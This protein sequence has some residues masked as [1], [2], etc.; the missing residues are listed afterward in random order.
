MNSLADKWNEEYESGKY[1]D[2]PAIPFVGTI[3]ETLN[4]FPETKKGLGLYVGCGNGRNYL[5]LV[6]AG[7]NL[8]GLDVS[9][10]ALQQI[11]KKMPHL[12]DKLV[13]QDFKSFSAA[14]QFDYIVAI[15]VFQ[16]GTERDAR[17]YFEKVCSLLKPG[18]LFFLRVNS[19]ATEIYHKYEVLEKNK[20][21]GFTIKYTEGPKS[22]LPVHF[23][24]NE[25]ILD[26]TREFAVVM[27]PVQE[28]IQREPPKK[29]CWAQWEGIFQK[30]V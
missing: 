8:N 28:M 1:A 14:K 11:S 10:V 16:H 29:G 4:K 23:Y 25:E 17:Q 24:S 3:I 15:Q 26:L 13:C 30:K 18:G 22:N 21:G 5:P 6:S 2:E 27:L 12:A 7:L 19:I 9:P 20:F